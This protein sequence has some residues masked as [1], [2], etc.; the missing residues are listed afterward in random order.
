MQLG[1]VRVDSVIDGNH[2][3]EPTR[4][5]LGDPSTATPG[6]G[7]DAE[8]W[9]PHRNV[10]TEDGM[11]DCGYGGFLIRSGDRVLLVDA[12][13]GPTPLGPW[14]DDGIVMRGGQLLD[15]LAELDVHPGDVTDIVITHLH[16]D[17]YGWAIEA[18]GTV[19]PNA[20]FR[21]H[22]LDWESHVTAIPDHPFAEGLRVVVDHL[23]TYDTDVQL[24]PGV[25]TIHAPG[26]TPGSTMVSIEGG[27]GRALLI[28][29]VA[30]CET[31]IVDE[32]W[33]TIADED[34]V[35]ARATRV[36]VI[37]EVEGTEIAVAGSHFSR[38]RFGH[39]RVDRTGRHWQHVD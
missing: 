18:G 36:E 23:E 7:Y 32:D 10:L 20:T 12:G 29:D 5:Y 34:P 39:V 15:N 1:N 26:H 38:L 33:A 8:D 2:L 16:L 14:G 3:F 25:R 11:M 17:H 30:H 21:C 9:E 19:F 13:L 35:T 37:R 4:F 31:E 28:G 27:D 22:A 24:A 6:L